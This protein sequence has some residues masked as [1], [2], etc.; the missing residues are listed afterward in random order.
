MCTEVSLEFN[1]FQVSLHMIV[2]ISYPL[3]D[4]MCEARYD[5][6]WVQMFDQYL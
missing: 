5:L 6:L 4:A 2:T 1:H 3:V